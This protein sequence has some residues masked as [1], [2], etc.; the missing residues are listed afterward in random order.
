[1]QRSVLALFLGACLALL[2][3]STAQAEAD[4]QFVLGFKTLRD[5]IGHDIVGQCLENE[6]YN[7]IGDSVQQ[8]TGGLLV[9]R[10][11]DNWTA[12]TD[13]YRTWINGPNGLQQ[14]LNTQRFG[15]GSRLCAGRRHRNAQSHAC[16]ASQPTP[17][18]GPIVDPILA[19]AYHVMRLS[20][21]GNAGAD[22]F[23]RSGASAQ[24]GALGNAISHWDL[25][26]SRIVINEEY[27]RE[28]PEALAYAL[29]WPT[30]MLADYK[31]NGPPQSW[32]ECMFDIALHH[33]FQ[34]QYWLD[35]FGE[36]GKQNPTQLEQWANR[37]M[38]LYR[39][40]TLG[41]WVVRQSAYQQFCAQFGG[42]PA[43]T[44]TP[45]PTPRPAPT[46]KPAP[47]RFVDPLLQEAMRIMRTTEF[48]EVLYQAY[49]G[50]TI[51]YIAFAHLERHG[52]PDAEGIHEGSRNR[53][54]LDEVLRDESHYVRVAV[55]VHELMHARPGRDYSDYTTEE[56]FKEETL[57]FS[58]QAKWWY[59][60]FGRDGKRN[61]TE[62]GTAENYR[63]QAWLDG[64]MGEVVRGSDGY[65][66][67][68]AKS[69]N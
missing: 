66:E 55:L 4:C 36:H 48:G 21:I 62:K 3:A 16:P 33:G 69:A 46:P 40:G 32:E 15:M 5:L 68:C 24:F 29:I 25:S 27:R 57:A 37:M 12:F 58:A 41:S 13:G 9:W 19:H 6:H 56:C 45:T 30:A 51:T 18:T 54:L 52:A 44:P 8:T 53:I 35:T 43:L 42:T 23:V 10:K 7:T 61:P 50:S 17:D 11:A 60:K 2:A 47:E 34:A 64:R 59:E 1:M 14:R 22:V 67:Q 65:Q 31:E 20:P 38:A 63:L 28:T 26:P 49:I 39:E